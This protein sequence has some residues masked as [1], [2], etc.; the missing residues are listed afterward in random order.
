MFNDGFSCDSLWQMIGAGYSASRFG[1]GVRL[2]DKYTVT[3]MPTMTATEYP[4]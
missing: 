1:I 3:A 4:R 2:Q